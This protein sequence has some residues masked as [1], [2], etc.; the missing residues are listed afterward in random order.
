MTTGPGDLSPAVTFHHPVLHLGWCGHLATEAMVSGSM[1]QR[2]LEI[3]SILLGRSHPHPPYYGQMR[4]RPFPLLNTSIYEDI[5]LPDK[6]W[7]C[8]KCPSIRVHVCTGDVIPH[9]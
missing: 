2:L 9:T 1:D 7:P 8:C 4:T 6:K 5:R 3:E